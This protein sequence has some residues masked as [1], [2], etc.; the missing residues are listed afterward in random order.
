MAHDY[1]G[2]PLQAGDHIILSRAVKSGGD[3]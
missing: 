1:L 2:N 3:L